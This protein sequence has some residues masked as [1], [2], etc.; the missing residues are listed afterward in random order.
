MC[1]ICG[2]VNLDGRPIAED[3]VLSGMMD[4]IIHRGPDDSGKYIKDNV[5]LGHRRLSI[6]D[7]EKGHQPIIDEER[8][9]IIVYNG[10][11][12]NFPELKTELLNKG[13]VFTTHS[14]TEVVLKAYKE[15]GA[16]CLDKFNGMFALAIWDKRDRSLFLARDRFGK[17]PLYYGTFGKTFIFASELKSL[18]RHPSVDLNV[19]RTSLAKYLAYDYIPAPRTII[20]G[21]HK[22]E[23]GYYAVLKD[24]VF[25]KKRYWDFSFK[26]DSGAITDLREAKTVFLDILKESVRKRLIS[27]VPLGVFLSG[28]VDSSAIVAMMSGLMDPADIKTFSIGFE[29]RTYDESDAAKKIALYFNT[30]HHEKIVGPRTL[31][32]TL[33]KMAHIID[34]PF[35]DSSI[36]PTYLVSQFAREKV[37]VALGGDGGDELFMGYPTFLGHKLASIYDRIPLPGKERMLKALVCLMPGS[38][39]YLSMRFKATRFLRGVRLPA[40][41]RHQMWVGSIPPSEQKSLFT[42]SGDAKFFDPEA[43]FDEGIAYFNRYPGIPDIDKV[44]YL[45]VKTYLTDDILHKVD[46]ASMANSLEVRAPF[47]DRDM[48]DFSAALSNSLKLRGFTTKYIMKESLKGLLPDGILNRPKHGFALPIGKWFRGDLKERLLEVFEPGKIKREGLFSYEHI[49]GMLDEHF[50]GRTDNSRKIWSVF[51]Y[52]MWHDNWI[53]KGAR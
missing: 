44:E 14:D 26:P 22:L 40:S 42:D 23:A 12:Y 41:L 21:I 50:F 3:R 18:F 9:L 7:L 33:P 8:G 34:E 45:Y 38:S 10:E 6:I 11:V 16:E 49:K 17:K 19:D 1:G 20:S 25:S 15:W 48:A 47:L 32:D 37:T 53:R 13:H 43:V 39:E 35:A 24:G 30:D 28:G 2:Y 4:A 46:R 52:Q 27:D 36:I 51:V 5:A 29:D 31:L